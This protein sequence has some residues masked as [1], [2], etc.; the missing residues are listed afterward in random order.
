MCIYI[1]IYIYTHTHTKPPLSG[2]PHLADAL[3]PRPAVPGGPA[4]GPRVYIYIYIYIYTHTLTYLSL[5]LYIYIYICIYIYIYI[6]YY[7]ISLYSRV[8]SMMSFG[9][10]L[11]SEQPTQNW[12]GQGESECLVKAKHCD[13]LR[14]C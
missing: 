10:S 2:A 12:S 6:L 13:G 11:C 3:R 8:Y 4:L 14:R 1:Y 5:S 7:I 9:L